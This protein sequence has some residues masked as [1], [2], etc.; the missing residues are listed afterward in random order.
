ME[1]Q[2]TLAE[3]LAQYMEAREA[4]Q[5]LRVSYPTL[6]RLADRGLIGTYQVPMLTRRLYCRADVE[7]LVA[8]STRPAMANRELVEA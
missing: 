6:A 5:A 4:R 3:Y 8:Q 2:K 7:R 1:I